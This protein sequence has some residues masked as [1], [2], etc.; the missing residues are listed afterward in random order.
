MPL[1]GSY[2]RLN[3]HNE[4]AKELRRKKL[5]RQDDKL[6]RNRLTSTPVSSEKT[7]FESVNPKKLEDIKHKIREKGNIQKRKDLIIIVISI[8]LTGGFVYYCY[9]NIIN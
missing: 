8:I 7:R 9:K 6:K 1:D 4:R 3:A 5:K 2:G